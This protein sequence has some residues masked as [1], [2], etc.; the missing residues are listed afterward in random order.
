[1]ASDDYAKPKRTNGER[2]YIWLYHRWKHLSLESRI[3]LRSYAL[4]IAVAT[5]GVGFLEVISLLLL[6]KLVEAPTVVSF[7]LVEL[8][9]F[10]L[11]RYFLRE[12]QQRRSVME[13]MAVVDSLPKYSHLIVHFV[14]IGLRNQTYPLR[15]EYVLNTVWNWAFWV[16]GPIR[17]LS[18]VGAIQRVEHDTEDEMYSW[19]KEHK[20]HLV[21]AYPQAYDLDQKFIPSRSDS[22]TLKESLGPSPESSQASFRRSSSSPSR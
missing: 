6:A 14:N 9:A 8:F 1:M 4:L 12:K 10:F 3:V 5:V 2:F 11:A 21:K 22:D 7:G 18:R 15:P 17:E 16:P 20:V 19:F 13:L